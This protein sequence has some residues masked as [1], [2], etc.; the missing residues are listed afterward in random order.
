VKR[1]LYICTGLILI[2]FSFDSCKTKQLAVTPKRVRH[3]SV[4][5]VIRMVREH[6]LD[7][8]TLSVKR[9]N[10]TLDNNGKSISVRGY[11][12]I[13][14]DSVIQI[15]AQKIAIPVGK[16]EIKTDSFHVVN[17]L[18]QENISG[19]FDYISSLLGIDVDYNIIQSILT[20]QLFAVKAESRENNF[21]D[22]VCEVENDLYKITSLRDRKLERITRREDRLER[23]KNRQEEDHLIK[24]DIYVDPDSFV[25]RKMAFND[26]D[27]NRKV[28][29]SYAK[30]EKVSNQ[31]FP[32]SIEIS[33]TSGNTTMKIDLDLSRI[34][35]ND[36]WN[37]NFAL[38]PRYRNRLLHE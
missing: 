6:T 12:K 26:M 37:F 5:R 4:G 23:Y 13:R 25:V 28:E 2:L 15:S 14:K 34:S 29:I 16:L 8:Q 27:F 33:F 21:R 20:G 1:F 31:W 11:F 24:Q 30:F 9:A 32:S 18:G 3:L 35:I 7:Y 10:V 38:S 22:Y 17:Y 36:D 19:S